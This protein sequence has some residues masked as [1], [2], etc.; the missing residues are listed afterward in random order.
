[1]RQ[2]GCARLTPIDAKDSSRNY[3]AYWHLWG[4]RGAYEAGN[5]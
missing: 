4:F 5:G 2:P 3:G 1:M